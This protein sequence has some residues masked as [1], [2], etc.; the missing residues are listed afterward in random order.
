MSLASIE[1]VCDIVDATV[2]SAIDCG[3]DKCETAI[4][5]LA[6]RSEIFFLFCT[7]CCTLLHDSTRNQFLHGLLGL[8][9][10][11]M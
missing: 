3:G 1:L 9:T 11:A 8:I 4:P 5:G 2:L 7:N 10:E 6:T